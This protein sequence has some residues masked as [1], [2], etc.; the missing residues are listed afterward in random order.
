VS[1]EETKDNENAESLKKEI[2]VLRLKVQRLSHEIEG[3]PIDQ[4]LS[5]R[6]VLALALTLFWPGLGYIII[7]DIAKGIAASIVTAVLVIRI[8]GPERAPME[9]FLIFWIIYLLVKVNKRAKQ[10]GY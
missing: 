4:G 9:L 3:K 2:E 1:V 10:L 8:F 5:I 7:G 6:R